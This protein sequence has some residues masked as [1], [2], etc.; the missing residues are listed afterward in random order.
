M[1]DWATCGK[2][3]RFMV[4]AINTTAPQLRK[5]CAKQMRR[6]PPEAGGGGNAR[7]FGRFR[8]F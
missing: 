4:Q 6:P 5:K 8:S 7:F 1:N 2:E 3:S